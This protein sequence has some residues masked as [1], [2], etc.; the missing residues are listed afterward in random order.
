MHTPQF[1]TLQ[2]Q[3]SLKGMGYVQGS[4]VRGPAAATDLHGRVTYL[5]EISATCTWPGDSNVHVPN[6]PIKSVQRISLRVMIRTLALSH[7]FRR[8]RIRTD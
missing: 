7:S 6:R 4:L 2:L 1:R 5:G 3:L 8:S